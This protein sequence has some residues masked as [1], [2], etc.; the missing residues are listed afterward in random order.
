MVL[1]VGIR[2]SVEETNAQFMQNYRSSEDYNE[3]FAAKKTDQCNVQ[4]ENQMIKE[5]RELLMKNLMKKN[6]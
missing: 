3:T 2:I 1:R 4:W 6:K 5:H